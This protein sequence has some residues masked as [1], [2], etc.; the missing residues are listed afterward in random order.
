MIGAH[1]VRMTEYVYYDYV[2][3]GDSKAA[4]GMQVGG[5]EVPN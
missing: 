1:G 2:C 5:S 3:G 4:T